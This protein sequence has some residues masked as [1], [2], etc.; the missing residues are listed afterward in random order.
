M[1]KGGVSESASLALAIVRRWRAGA[2]LLSAV[3]LLVLTPR[4][5]PAGEV[6]VV[7]TTDLAPH[8]AVEEAFVREMKHPV[9]SLVVTHADFKAQVRALASAELVFAIGPD[10]A[11]A[12]AA[13]KGPRVLHALVPAPA[14]LG[15]D[16][17]TPGIPAWPR[18]ATALAALQE[19]VP[20]ARRVGILT[21][22]SQSGEYVARCRLA[23]RGSDIVF[24]IR[25]VRARAEVPAA[26]RAMLPQVDAIWFVP[27]ATVVST[28]NVGLLVEA[29]LETG[30]PA[31]GNAEAQV[32]AGLPLGLEPDWSD[33]GRRAADAAGRL[34]A[35]AS[36]NLDPPEGRLF[37]NARSA[38]ALHL[39]LT[40][41]LRE[42][43]AKVFE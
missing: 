24:R 39:V 11:L 32:R 17:S 25:E 19:L 21:D 9:R 37:L 4:A 20:T 15:L 34:L 23:A 33:V 5:A 38:S 16:P 10:A 8:R 41:A 1:G 2:A 26:L 27:D 13:L 3:G 43:A 28:E 40:P 7:R 30:T 29:T 12:A 18:P 36:P 35:S 42:R 6:V 22:P 31:L 14:R